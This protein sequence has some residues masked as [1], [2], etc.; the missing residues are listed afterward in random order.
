[1]TVRTPGVEA[2]T[3][4]LLVAHL[5]A[6]GGLVLA[7]GPGEPAFLHLSAQTGVTGFDVLEDSDPAAATAALEALGRRLESVELLLVGIEGIRVRGF[8][9][10]SGIP[11]GVLGSGPKARNIIASDELQDP[12]W[13][14]KVR[15]LPAPLPDAEFARLRAILCPQSLFVPSRSTAD[16]HRADRALARLQLDLE[17]E[18]LAMLPSPGILLIT[19]S[20][21][22]G[23]TLMAAARARRLAVDHPGWR[24]ALICFNR[25]L[26]TRLEGLVADTPS[27]EVE[28][29]YSWAA[30]FGVAVEMRSADRSGRGVSDAI[31]RGLGRDAYDAVVCDE[32]Q[33]FAAAWFRFAWQ[34]V[35]SDRGGLTVFA[36]AAQ[37]LYGEADLRS[38]TDETILEHKLLCGYRSTG[39][40][41]KAA[42]DATGVGELPGEMMPGR[43]VQLVWAAR[44]DAQ[45]EFIGWEIESLVASGD[46][47]LRDIGLLYT[48]RAGSVNRLRAMLD[49]HH[50]PYYWVNKD[51]ASR[52]A[53]PDDDSVR[54]LTVH[55]AKGLEFPVV[56]LFGLEALKIDGVDASTATRF[57]RIAYVGMTRAEDLLT[58]TYTRPNRMLQQLRASDTV[59]QW[60]WPDDYSLE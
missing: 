28:T 12:I 45:A 22:T 57:N 31:A 38:W 10:C 51:P 1:M 23:K 3:S 21:G 50:I 13:L 4:A 6:A 35:R 53:M 25:T 36:D 41:L 56:F 19:G 49:A 17:Q 20:A 8:L 27:I 37:A 42:V 18:R 9:V 54:L 15:R 46:Y 55:A 14:T 44:W 52:R 11:R 48:Q 59:E 34:T 24:V 26:A 39:P 29:F 7:G 43:C 40:I 60:T 32:G 16:P 58:I 5:S 33:D 2:S 47:R 30:A